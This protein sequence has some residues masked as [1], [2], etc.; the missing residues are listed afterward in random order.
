MKKPLEGIRIIEFSHVISGP[1]CGMLLG[2]LGAEMIKIERPGEGD[3]T[4]TAGAKTADGISIWYP[5]FNRNK[6][7]ITLNFKNPKAKE[8]VRDLVKTSDALIENFRPG[9]LGEMGLGFEDL[10]KINPNII[11][12][13]ISGFGKNGPYEKKTAF[14][15]TA[16]AMGGFMA[17]NGLPEIPLKTGPAVSDFLSGLYGALAV[18]SALRYRDKTGKGQFI[19][20]SMMDSV[21]SILESSFAEYTVLGREPQRI[22][23]RRP[24]NAVSTVFK[25][26]D[27]YI[28]IAAMFQSQ[29]ENMCRLMNREDLLADPRIATMQMRYQH[30]DELEKIVADWAIDKTVAEIVELLEKFS[31]PNA[32]VQRIPEVIEDPNVKA[33][34]SIVYFDYPGIGKYPVAAFTPRFSEIPWEMKRPDL[35]GESN[36][37]VFCNLLDYT[38]AEF[39]TMQE[40]GII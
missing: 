8:I 14:D 13:S 15:M 11:M 38:E 31:I 40:E 24:N 34:D 10:K 32:P 36:K 4:R 3:Y 28:Y 16:V 35:L 5:A 33:R 30:A 29:W 17:V 39:K 1:F 2:D 23:N 18:V 12:A 25:A 26:K 19:D 20:I 22:G 27:N 9:L 7:S 37:D 6:K 21:M